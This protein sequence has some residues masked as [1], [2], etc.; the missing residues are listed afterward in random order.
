LLKGIVPER[1]I[2]ILNKSSVGTI[3]H[4]WIALHYFAMFWAVT[5][6]TRLN[7]TGHFLGIYVGAIPAFRHHGSLY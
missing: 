5:R 7:S 2:P 6:I 1:E 3:N 4:L